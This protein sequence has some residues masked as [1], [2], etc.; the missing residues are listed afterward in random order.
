MES[1]KVSC[2]IL[3]S[4]SS[5][6]VLHRLPEQRCSLRSEVEPN[7]CL[8]CLRRDACVLT[9]WLNLYLNCVCEPHNSSVVNYRK[10]TKR[11]ASGQATENSGCKSDGSSRIDM[12]SI[13]KMWTVT[14]PEIKGIIHPKIIYSHSSC[15]KL[16]IY[17][18]EHKIIFKE[19]PR[20][21]W[22]NI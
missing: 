2:V 8:V 5:F 17:F 21:I 20:H 15:P 3:H 18:V 19:H 12:I 22:Y 16:C 6:S 14:R 9:L 11:K 4:L 1:V 7:S 10:Q 13:M